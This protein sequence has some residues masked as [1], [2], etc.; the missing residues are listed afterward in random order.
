MGGVPHV[1]REAGRGHEDRG[2]DG[3]VGG[4]LAWLSFSGVARRRGEVGNDLD[5]RREFDLGGRGGDGDDA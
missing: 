3:T 1:A 2:R 5:L 4:G